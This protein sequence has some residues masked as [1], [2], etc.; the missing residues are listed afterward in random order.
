ME[1]NIC[2]MF[3]CRLVYPIGNLNEVHIVVD[4]RK[5]WVLLGWLLSNIPTPK[6]ASE[7]ILLNLYEYIMYCQCTFLKATFEG[8]RPWTK[9]VALFI[10]EESTT[11][12]NYSLQTLHGIWLIS[13]NKLKLQGPRVFH[14]TSTKLWSFC[15]ISSSII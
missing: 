15:N 10:E 13:I 8:Q 12:G 11:H 5:I 1:N 4:E 3:F 14:V 7:A 9:Y 2:C 6:Q